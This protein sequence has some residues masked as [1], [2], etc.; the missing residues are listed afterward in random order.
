MTAAYFRIDIY[1]IVFL[2]I[3]KFCD[4]LQISIVYLMKGLKKKTGGIAWR[5]KNMTELSGCI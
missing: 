5:I 4:I 1:G 3:E 2:G